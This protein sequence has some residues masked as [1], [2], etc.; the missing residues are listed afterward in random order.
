MLDRRPELKLEWDTSKNTGDPTKFSYGSGE[1]KWWLCSLGH[2]YPAAIRHR[3]N[4]TGCPYCS[5]QKVLTGF[6]DLATLYPDLAAEWAECN[7]L[8]PTEVTAGSGREVYWLCS[9]GHTYPA[10]IK[11]RVVGRGCPYC[12]GQRVWKGDNDFKTKYPDIA[13]QWRLSEHN[14]QPDEVTSSSHEEVL[15]ECEFGHIWIA[16]VK[17]RT[18]GTGCPICNNGSIS[19]KEKTVLYY[20]QQVFKDVIGNYYPDWAK[21]KEIDIYIPS[22]DLSIEYDGAHWHTD[23]NRDKEKDSILL[24]AKKKIIRIREF[25][26]PKLKDNSICYYLGKSE[27]LDN[28]IIWLFKY[29]NDNYHLKIPIDIDSNRDSTEINQLVT[30]TKKENSLAVTHPEIAKE[31]DYEKNGSLRPEHVTYGSN[32]PVYWKCRN[33]GESYLKPIKERTIRNYACPYCKIKPISKILYKTKKA[34]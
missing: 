8:K 11:K 3:V 6:N 4:G 10:E 27:P 22:I 12:A 5:G 7:E 34:A 1:T 20:L 30:C 25:G 32:R 18:E 2:S 23:E 19:I 16:S 15:W 26:L 21:G 13:A 14:Y 24:E 17:S 28:A 31:W 29:I 33:C 9:R